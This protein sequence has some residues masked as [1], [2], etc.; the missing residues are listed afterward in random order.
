MS[1]R[2]LD[3]VSTNAPPEKRM[4]SDGPSKPDL[5]SRLSDE[6]VLHILS[7][8]PI[9]SLSLCQRLS[10]R[11]YEL[12][13]D[14]EL[15]K[16]KY[17]SRWVWPRARRIRQLKDSGLSTKP[18]SYTPR[19]YRWIGHENSAKD[20]ENADW[21][22]QYRLRH[23]WSRGSC[24]VTEVEVAQPSVPPVLAKM[25]KGL[26]FTA[27]TSNGLRAW[28][29]GDTK[30]CL[31]KLSLGGTRGAEGLSYTPTSIAVTPQDD[32]SGNFEVTLGFGDGSFSVY[33]LNC[34]NARF[35]F[36]FSHPASSN[37]AVT[38]LA[39]SSSYL[40]TLSQNQ[41]LSLYRFCF[42]PNL[43]EEEDQTTRSPKLI[44]SL[45]ANNIFAPLSLSIRSL[46]T[47]IVASIAYSFSRIGCGWSVGL[48]ELRMSHDGENL[49]SRL[50]TT[51]DLQFCASPFNP[52]TRRHS[53][54]TDN[55]SKDRSVI[56]SPLGPSL[57]YTQVPTSL[58]YCHPY[59]L[60]S[61]AD[62]TLTM[63]LVV[64]TSSS[65]TIKTGRRLWG[66]TSSVSGVQ[67]SD[68]GKAVS[69]SSRGGEIRI[70][71]LEDMI[72]SNGSSTRTM[73]QRDA[74]V[75]IS[76]G[77]ADSTERRLQ[78]PTPVV[79]LE[80]GAFEK[81]GEGLGL[82]LEDVSR[83]LTLARMR[84]WVGFDDEQVVVLRER[85]LGTQLL[86]CYDFT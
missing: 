2:R 78:Q 10:R 38:A 73:L 23:N 14:S 70:W 76:P 15:W 64:S 50:A 19:P 24:R 59:L 41:T 27:D 4:R 54:S 18:A 81:R 7:F 69:V 16:R 79:E 47:E 51:V 5:L 43:A 68:R 63:Y 21:K 34:D 60:T 55:S 84:G 22:K 44:A 12:A 3:D 33:T 39:S 9:Q 13:G 61:H 52:S 62:N 11:F 71:E 75:Q 35:D 67:V 17:Y 28:T 66:H 80:L 26:V 31:A 30:S 37:G 42:N 56:S 65:L 74:S 20:L 25:C 77:N 1:K 86:G 72:S 32:S 8:L 58:S 82:T 48:Q 40:L 46:S 85:G 53:M 49:G 29:T 57:S 6:L 45:K 36:Q 83:E